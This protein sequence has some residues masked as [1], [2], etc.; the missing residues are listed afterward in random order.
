MRLTTMRLP[1]K[2][3]TIR[4]MHNKQANR[5]ASLVC[6]KPILD[7]QETQHSLMKFKMILKVLKSHLTSE[8]A[9]QENNFYHLE[10]AKSAIRGLIYCLLLLI[11]SL[12]SV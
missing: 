4:L 10:N 9:S 5:K 12:N 6:N 1:T 2:S 7:F 11:I 3:T 8:A